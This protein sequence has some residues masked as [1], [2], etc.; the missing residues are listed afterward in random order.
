M[1]KRAVKEQRLAHSQRLFPDCIITPQSPAPKIVK[2]LQRA[3]H[4]DGK[5]N[6]GDPCWQIPARGFVPA[7]R[8]YRR[9]DRVMWGCDV[10]H[11][12]P[13][14]LSQHLVIRP[15]TH[16]SK[17]YT[18]LKEDD[19]FLTTK[20][21]LLSGM[22]M[23]ASAVLLMTQMRKRCRKQRHKSSTTASTEKTVS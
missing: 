5:G 15:A 3:I 1:C 7:V 10:D 20:L 23:G 19:M 16:I 9:P 2:T 4:R 13:F 8:L 11:Y 12:V 22:F 6:P 18:I 17:P 14:K 21:N